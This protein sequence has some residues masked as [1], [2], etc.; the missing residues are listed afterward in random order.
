MKRVLW[1]NTKSLTCLSVSLGDKDQCSNC[2]TLP[3]NRIHW[4]N[5][6]AIR[7]KVNKC[8]NRAICIA[9]DK[10]RRV[11]EDHRRKSM[12]SK[13]KRDV[14]LTPQKEPST[15]S[16][17]SKRTNMARTPLIT[18]RSAF[19]KI[20]ASSRR[21]N[22][23]MPTPATEESAQTAKYNGIKESEIRPEAPPATQKENGVPTLDSSSNLDACESSSPSISS[24]RV[25]K[26]LFPAARPS[27]ISTD[28]VEEE[29]TIITRTILD[30]IEDA[31]KMIHD[32]IHV[33]L[34]ANT[35]EKVRLYAIALA[36]LIFKHEYEL[37]GKST[38]VIT[39]K[40]KLPSQNQPY[41]TSY[42]L[43]TKGSSPES[44]AN[45]TKRN[46]NKRMNINRSKVV[47]DILKHMC[48]ED[49][50]LGQRNVIERTIRNMGDGGVIRWERSH[51]TL[52]ECMAV[53]TIATLSSNAIAKILDAVSVFLNIKNLVPGQLKKLIGQTE[54][55]ELPTVEYQ[56]IDLDAGKN[57]VAS[58]VYYF[59]KNIAL[60]IEG[61]VA[62]SYNDG[63]FMP[64]KKFSHFRDNVILLR[65]IDRGGEVLIDLLRLVNR[66]E[67]NTGFRCIPIGNAED[68]MET[69]NNLSKTCYS[70]ERNKV[71]QCFYDERVHIFTIVA[72]YP[73]G[74]TDEIDTRCILAI[75]EVDVPNFKPEELR[76]K[77]SQGSDLLV[78][79]DEI[80]TTFVDANHANRALPSEIKLGANSVVEDEEDKSYLTHFVIRMVRQ[81][82]NRDQSNTIEDEEDT[83]SYVGCQIY[84]QDDNLLYSFRFQKP[85]IHPTQ[86]TVE[87]EMKCQYTQ[88][89]FTDDNKMTALVTG[90]GTCS[91]SFPCCCCI[92]PKTSKSVPACFMAHSDKFPAGTEFKD[93]P[94]R[95]GALSFDKAF[96]RYDARMGPNELFEN[97]KAQNKARKEAIFNCKSASKRPLRPIHID[98]IHGDALHINEGL[99]NHLLQAALHQLKQ[100]RLRVD[101][102]DSIW[103]DTK[104]T[105][106]KEV[107]S[108]MK[109]L[110]TNTEYRLTK[111][112]LKDYVD[113]Y[114]SAE[115]EY[116]KKM[117]NNEDSAD[118]EEFKDQLAKDILKY[119][120]DEGYIYTNAKLRGAKELEDLIGEMS[121]DKKESD[122]NEAA[123][124]FTTSV[125]NHCS[126]FNKQHGGLEL[127]GTRSILLTEHAGAIA[128]TTSQAYKI[129]D[130]DANRQINEIMDWFKKVSSHLHPLQKML[131]SQEK[132]AG[133]RLEEFKLHII[134]YTAEWMH[135]V[136]WKNP[137]FWKLH[138][139]H[140]CMLQ[141]VERTGMCGIESAEGPENKHSQ[142]NGIRAMMA[143]IIS[144]KVRVQKEM[145]RQTTSLIKEV[146]SNVSRVFNSK[147]RK[148]KRGRYNIVKNRR[149][150]DDVDHFISE[151]N[152]S[153]FEAP[154]DGF[155]ITADGY[156]LQ[157]DT[158]DLYNHLRYK[159]VPEHMREVIENDDTIGSKATAAAKYHQ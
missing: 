113:A 40:H 153:P 95:E 5:N 82:S 124:L 143:P 52:Y 135:G 58:C 13:R 105:Q 130:P 94:K 21:R 128:D 138:C 10:K 50:I 48:H 29:H 46:S 151:V 17:E 49:N 158:E 96:Q 148:G 24:P 56:T 111:S 38:A 90:I 110:A 120:K 59:V 65:S 4:R 152:T 36:H 70:P 68:A 43:L 104:V 60:L 71:F 35:N 3:P 123:Y 28:S 107:L 7:T 63:T 33:C 131:K 16:H 108:Q 80:V 103:I 99:G 159:Q 69:Y 23:R 154:P 9:K 67:G 73:I 139:L 97:K 44:S 32:N 147:K 78:E 126:Q 47:L 12:K 92:R 89:D 25:S 26:N 41:K 76:I 116:D 87:F 15:P 137:I 77:C 51:L 19:G 66:R 114:V 127:T 144:T 27:P 141:Y 118:A 62:S 61:I 34:D 79:Q 157:N 85:I 45:K 14:I 125:R 150:D 1:S 112:T 156:L 102:I 37:Q 11:E 86:A 20:M 106:A 8:T 55:N 81:T 31:I 140:C 149:I 129:T 83:S 22:R 84:D 88:L 93:Y 134:N 57:K 91:E 145:H 2:R 18:L 155:F 115:K 39:I 109:T 64:S 119:A 122:L 117:E 133:D 53:Q 101:N 142:M 132:M 30:E 42:A 72:K 75:F 121:G 100:V 146:S 74:E 136:T 98:K 6:N 54:F